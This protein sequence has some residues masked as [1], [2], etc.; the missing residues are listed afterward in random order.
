V[1]AG[2][3]AGR[4]AIIT[5]ASR[6]L[7]AS[8]AEAFWQAGADLLLVARSGPA[9][10]DVRSR[11]GPRRGQQAHALAADLAETGT[12]AAV[13]AQA[14]KVF[15][16]LDVLVNN[17]AVQTPIGP[18]WE[19]DWDEWQ[20]A[21]HLDLLAPVQ[22]CRL[23]VPW[24]AERRQGKIVNL[25]GG[26]AAGPRPRF[27]AYGTAKAAL[28]RFSETLAEET[29]A[30]GIAVNCVAPG[31]LPTALVEDIVRAGPGAAGPD[32]YEKARR[33]LA[34]GPEALRRAA[35]LCVFLASSASDGITGKLISAVW[36]PWEALPE[37]VRELRE[38]DVYTLRRIVPGERGFSWGERKPV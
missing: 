14:R 3:L 23:C 18:V 21:F 29:R 19:N 38:T 9:L 24:M 27:S 36:D 20:R 12:P 4:R 11:L 28:V 37:H 8:V 35:R 34:E 33:I 25:S 1:K 31:A 15:P 26:G 22:L 16:A 2:P 10:E 30:V 32:E 7:G 13:M 6:G 17:A 5:G